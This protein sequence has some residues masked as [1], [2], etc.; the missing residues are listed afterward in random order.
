MTHSVSRRVFSGLA[1]PMFAVAVALGAA[2]AL[3]EQDVPSPIAIGTVQGRGDTSPL[4]GR[5]VMVEGVV[6]AMFDG[7]AQDAAGAPIGGSLQDGGDDDPATSDALFFI[8]RGAVPQGRRVRVRGLVSEVDDGRGGSRTALKPLTVVLL[9]EARSGEPYLPRPTRLTAP[10]TD[11][12]PYEAMRVRIDAPL[13]V[14]STHRAGKYGE[15]LVNF[16]ERIRAPTEVA[17]PGEA[18]KALAMQNSRRRLWLD[19]ASD[20]ESPARLWWLPQGLPRAGSRLRR[21]E[22]VLDQAQGTYGLRLTA[23][24]H[25]EPAPRPPA[26][27][28]GGDLR[29]VAFN[30]E[31]LFNGDGHG[32]GFPTPRGARTA[33]EY[34][35]QLDRHLATIRALKPD[36]LA[37]MELENDGYGPESSIAALVAAMRAA[38]LGDDWRFVDAGEGPGTDQIRVALLYRAGRVGTVGA[39]AM[40]TGGP[41]GQRSRVPLAQSFRALGRTTP[42]PVFTVAVNH[43]KS[44][45]CGNPTGADADQG[46]GQG[47]WNATRT[48]SARRLSAWLHSDPTRSGSDLAMI[49]GDLNAYGMEDPVQTL[50]AD[51][52][53]DAYAGRGTP[54]YS[55]V[56]DGQTG[57][58]DHALLSSGLVRRLAGAAKWHSNADEPERVEAVDQVEE[59]GGEQADARAAQARPAPG[60]WRSSDHDPLLLGF[61]L[62]R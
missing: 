21:V 55:Y 15:L 48:D 10:P 29:I 9:D 30:L 6:T 11:W 24:P 40:L 56:F 23:V 59:Q 34:R 53:R 14:A 33:E 49:V 47:C 52:W 5:E 43:F 16:G 37:L 8:G 51:G 4:I 19:D 62:R 38:G 58:L 18:A 20:L 44:K 17:M 3:A 26:P 32:G 39:P 60:P 41:F 2:S 61:R 25:P 27:K 35:A 42:G 7:Q 54:P 12:E 31:N 46:D 13:T 22:G 45:G 1:R 57:R 28:V 36:V 50:I